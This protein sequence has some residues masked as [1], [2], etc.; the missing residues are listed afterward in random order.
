MFQRSKVHT[1]IDQQL[2]F[3]LPIKKWSQSIRKWELNPPCQPTYL[4]VH[5]VAFLSPG[6]EGQWPLQNPTELKCLHPLQAKARELGTAFQDLLGE[7]TPFQWK[8]QANQ[9]W[10]L[11]TSCTTA[12]D[13]LNIFPWLWNIFSYLEVGIIHG[14]FM[15]ILFPG[16]ETNTNIFLIIYS[17]SCY[18]VQVLKTYSQSIFCLRLNRQQTS[19][20]YIDFSNPYSH[21][22]Q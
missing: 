6:M 17:V 7:H 4:P 21:L 5:R 14:V 9:C 10:M 19:Q 15:L 1:K 8:P 12:A 2:I 18:S 20:V 16:R 3:K 13:L 11:K 22:L